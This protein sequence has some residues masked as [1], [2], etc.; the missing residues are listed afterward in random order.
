MKTVVITLLWA[1]SLFLAYF[2]GHA[3][4][5]LFDYG[6]PAGLKT[7]IGGWSE[8]QV[9]TNDWLRNYLCGIGEPSFLEKLSTL[10]TITADKLTK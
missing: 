5:N 7:V 10:R 9:S 6:A 4:S 2:A 3:V 8:A 1:A